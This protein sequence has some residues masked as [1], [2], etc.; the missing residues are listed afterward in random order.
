MDALRVDVA[1]KKILCT[2]PIP[3]HLHNVQLRKWEWQVSNVTE[4]VL[5]PFPTSWCAKIICFL[6]NCQNQVCGPVEFMLWFCS[7]WDASFMLICGL[8]ASRCSYWLWDAWHTLT[9]KTDCEE[10]VVCSERNK[11]EQV[12]SLQS[13]FILCSLLSCNFPLYVESVVLWW[14]Y[15]LYLRETEKHTRAN[16]LCSLE[17]LT[18]RS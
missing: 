2:L 11:T 14:T 5:C 13:H 7:D 16:L 12:S 3:P 17:T 10:V 18:V 6:Y 1:R 9:V 15:L 8:R 4:E